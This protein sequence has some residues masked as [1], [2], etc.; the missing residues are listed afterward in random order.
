MDVPPLDE[1]VRTAQT[2]VKAAIKAEL[3]HTL[4]Q[5]SVRR[6]VEERLGLDTGALD[7]KE[8]KAPLNEAIQIAIAEPDSGPD[9]DTKPS[10]R[11]KSKASSAHSPPKKRKPED[12]FEDNNESEV[13]EDVKPSKKSMKP[14]SSSTMK[15]PAKRKGRTVESDEDMDIDDEPRSTKALG[16]RSKPQPKA[17][18][19]RAAA[20]PKRARVDEDGEDE[21][22]EIEVENDDADF[23]A[24]EEEE[25]PKS[26]RAKVAS[27]KDK[28][29]SKKS[30][31]KPPA[32]RRKS[33]SAQQT[34]KTPEN[35]PTSDM[36]QE[37]ERA[38]P[39]PKVVAKA[40]SVPAAR[41]KKNAILSDDED[42]ANERE[43]TPKPSPKKAK[44]PTPKKKALETKAEESGSELS[45]LID[46]PVKPKR[47]SKASESK[48]K[49]EKA[50]ATKKK[51]A[52]AKDADLSKDEKEIKRLKVWAKLF[53]DLNERQQISELKKM[54]SD[55]GM[56]GKLSMEKARQIKEKREFEQELKDVV[57]FE[58][59]VLKRGKGSSKESDEEGDKSDED[60][61]KPVPLRR[62]LRAD[63]ITHV[64]SFNPHHTVRLSA[65]L[66]T[67]CTPIFHVSYPYSVYRGLY[68]D[69]VKIIRQQ[70]NPATQGIVVEQWI[71]LILTYARHR[72]LFTLRVDDAEEKG[73]DWDEIL[74]N[75]RINRP[76]KSSYL[77]DIIST[78]V[79]KNV[80]A[81]EPSK[82][83]RSVLVYWR[84]PEE[85]AEVLHDWANSTGQM[86][87]I[88]T[89]YEIT[90]PPIESPLTG[91]PIPLLRKAI[92]IL[93]KGNR[94]QT[95]AISDGEGVRFFPAK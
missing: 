5:K 28:A 21:A 2:I 89:F 38:S 77:S 39:P 46:E 17:S 4:S 79:T 84:Q 12:A 68:T 44:I 31:P 71:R 72:K 73:S 34:Y 92:A 63:R 82:Q 93:V 76:V 95:I 85:W 40:A 49:K 48:S 52:K 78:M 62:G 20:N 33:S 22:M 47:K 55:L 91:I 25:K 14:S 50:P 10:A 64:F 9:E 19:S 11:R 80:A 75:E 36:E 27:G 90:D 30:A 51:A 69:R 86:N 56:T 65:T 57:E 66:Y 15:K 70:P 24:S 61:E 67:L 54:L 41:A 6:Q 37:D 81:Y 18:T 32:V 94:A 16:S 53:A 59:K 43:H 3:L 29:A 26:K 60:G 87:T 35:V 74:R 13:E 58:Q 1:L 42:S 88:M 45:E 83:T 8:Y 7:D 23:E